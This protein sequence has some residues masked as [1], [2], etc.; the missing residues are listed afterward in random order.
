LGASALRDCWGASLRLS[1]AA[2]AQHAPPAASAPTLGGV[3]S[4]GNLLLLLDAGSDK[5]VVYSPTPP[6]LG[7]PAPFG[8]PLPLPLPPQL[9]HAAAS[10]AP[11]AAAA[12]ALDGNAADDLANLP[13]A[14]KALAGFEALA[15][16]ADAAPLKP[17]EP[18]A[19]EPEAP[20]P[21]TPA[22]PPL[23][24]PPPAD[25]AVMRAVRRRADARRFTPQVAVCSAG[26]AD[27]KAHFEASLVEDKRG[28][29]SY[30]AFAT[31]VLGDV[32]RELEAR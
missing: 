6:P 18:A 25:C 21:R 24:F 5:I 27:A 11:A 9:M 20:K 3:P 26:S 1:H 10:P 7:A 8:A 4:T 16:L 19:P 29:T 31:T 13:G 2:V 28:A 12:G 23:A 15:A 14:A 32:A 22:E 17:P 30:A